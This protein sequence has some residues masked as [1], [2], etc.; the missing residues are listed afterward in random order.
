MS[1]LESEFPLPDYMKSKLPDLEQQIPDL[2]Q[3]IPDLEQQIPYLEQQIPDL[4]QQIPDLEQQIPDLEY[5]LPLP[6]LEG[7]DDENVWNG[8]FHQRAKYFNANESNRMYFL[9]V[10]DCCISF[11]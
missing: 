1:D 11:Q 7:L 9:I 4:E 5:E 3:E 8:N 2:E 6:D 10:Y